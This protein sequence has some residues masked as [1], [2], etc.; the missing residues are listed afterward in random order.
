MRATRYGV[1][2]Y[3]AHVALAL[4]ALR[5]QDTDTAMRHLREAVQAPPSRGVDAHLFGLDT[6]L[7]N[8]LLDHG[9]RESV[10]EFLQRRPTWRPSDRERLLKDAA[11]IRAGQMPLSYQARVSRR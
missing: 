6:R 5:D 9:E 10:A 4:H 8:Y 7:M 11:A 1:A 3:R 2:V